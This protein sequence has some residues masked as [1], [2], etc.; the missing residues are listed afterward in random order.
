MPQTKLKKSAAA[1]RI[2]AE[3]ANSSFHALVALA[4]AK[5]A[6][7][8]GDFAAAESALIEAQNAAPDAMLKDLASLRLAKVQY[9]LG[10]AD[11][12]LK[13]L[14]SIRNPGYRLGRLNLPAIFICPRDKPNRHTKPTAAP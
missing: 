4:D 2:R 6:V 1:A 7:S 13:S 11:A 5:T 8:Q 14:Q 3:F 9:G 12:A 10:N